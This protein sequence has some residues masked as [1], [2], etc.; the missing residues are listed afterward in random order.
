MMKVKMLVKSV[1]DSKLAQ[2]Q[3]VA[4]F[5]VLDKKLYSGQHD[6]LVCKIHDAFVGKNGDDLHNCIACTLA[7]FS[8]LLWISVGENS[9]VMDQYHGF[10][11]FVMPAYLMV[12]RIEQI[13]AMIPLSDGYRKRYYP[14]FMKV[15]RWANFIKHPKGFMLVHHPNYYFD[16]QAMLTEEK[17][18]KEVLIKDDFIDTYYTGPAKN[19]ELYSLLT[20]NDK[21]YV[22]L[23]GLEEFA[24]K[25]TDEIRR[26]TKLVTDNPFVR[27]VLED[28]STLRQYYENL[29]FPEI[30]EVPKQTRKKKNK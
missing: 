7:D 10:T 6:P 25:F 4:A 18:K 20:N 30:E 1:G 12:E 11:K 15:R 5:K 24:T 29:D 16:D 23:P 17:S 13:M 19:A 2:K 9:Y 3:V 22:L 21:V 8:N 28:K 14:T 27:E 26:F